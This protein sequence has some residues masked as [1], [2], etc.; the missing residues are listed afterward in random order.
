MLQMRPGFR[1]NIRAGCTA[2]STGIGPMIT[3]TK[4]VFNSASLTNNGSAGWIQLSPA[5]SFAFGT[6]D[7][8]IEFWWQPFAASTQ[9]IFGTRPP[10]TNGAY[11]SFSQVNVGLVL[12]VFNTLQLSVPNVLT[13][14]AWTAV[15]L[16]RYAGTTKVYINGVAQSSTWADTTS[17]L[18]YDP[19]IG[20]DDYAHGG[21]QMNGCLD[22]FRVSN[23]A[24]YTSN[25]TPATQPFIDDLNT[26]CLLHFD[27]PTGSTTF[28]DDNS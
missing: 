5:S 26:I 14:N 4:G 2:I 27:G 3:T 22:E 13:V 24:R 18:A 16:V 12:Y 10:N 19:V 21:L 17:Y 7:F 8:T 20:T 28:V 25:Y 15:A 1:E 6:S 9:T 11:I 23:V